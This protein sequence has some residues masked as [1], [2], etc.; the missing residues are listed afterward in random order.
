ML[1]SSVVRAVTLAA[2][3]SHV[4]SCMCAKIVSVDEEDGGFILVDGDGS[5]YARVDDYPPGY[6]DC[7]GAPVR[8]AMYSYEPMRR[9]PRYDRD[10]FMQ[11]T[12]SLLRRF[13]RS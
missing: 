8:S 2:L 4:L 12:L 9:M 6:V 7:D 10:A 3:A 1:R 5:V 11:A 13:R